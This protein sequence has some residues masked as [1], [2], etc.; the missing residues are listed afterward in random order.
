MQQQQHSAPYKSL[1]IRNIHINISY[2]NRYESNET[3][4]N[5]RLFEQQW[6]DFHW[7]KKNKKLYPIYI[8]K[9]YFGIR[10]RREKKKRYK[11]RENITNT[12]TTIGDSKGYNKNRAIL[13]TVLEERSLESIIYQESHTNTLHS[14]HIHTYTKE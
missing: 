13:Y 7:E 6:S 14:T 1:F 9:N 4:W 8:L 10:R 12:A 11:L 3:S 2:F 5:F